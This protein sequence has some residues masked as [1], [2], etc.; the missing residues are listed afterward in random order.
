[1]SVLRQHAPEWDKRSSIQIL[2]QLRCR[3]SGSYADDTS[4]TCLKELSTLV[5]QIHTGNV[6]INLS[7]IWL[8]VGMW[9]ID[10]FANAFISQ[11]G[12]T[13]DRDPINVSQAWCTWRILACLTQ[14]M[15]WLPDLPF[16]WG[17][18][19]PQIWHEHKF[20]M[21]ILGEWM[22]KITRCYLRLELLDC[23]KSSDF[24]CHGPATI[25]QVS[26]VNT[27]VALL[28]CLSSS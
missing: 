11:I 18:L 26:P 23:D 4:K 19:S 5:V 13:Y 25:F 21:L 17:K 20:V 27:C 16:Y 2:P 12:K 14:A 22:I 10:R 8:T 3:G 15:P 24:A 1:M 9:S 6:G 28:P 7:N